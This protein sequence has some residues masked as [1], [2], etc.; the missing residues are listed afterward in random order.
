MSKQ[1]TAIIV[2]DERPAR[3]EL[4]FLL[5]AYKHVQVLALCKN[6]R[7][8]Q[9][10]IE[11]LRP[12]V[13]F[14]DIRMSGQSGFDLLAQL[15]YVPEVIFTTAYE[16]FALQAFEENALDYLLKPIREERLAKALTR[17]DEKLSY[18][19]S[20]SA[21][22][23]R[24]LFLKDGI[25]HYFVQLAEVYLFESWG[26]Y[27]KFCFGDKEVLQYTTLKEVESWLPAEFIRANRRQM[28]N[29]K[30]IW[31]ITSYQIRNLKIILSNG[32]EVIVSHRQAAQFRSQFPIVK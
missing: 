11:R 27:T 17:V 9:T 3:E 19:Q 31:Q 23:N 16:Q 24:Q 25:R 13:V 21:S 29:K 6:A 14:L 20:G 2:D 30:F 10:E 28:L 18:R 15:N 12:D 4:A 32:K 1:I 7:E 26:N 22:L 5:K 8:A